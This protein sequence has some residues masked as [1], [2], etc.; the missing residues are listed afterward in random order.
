[1]PDG[2][3]EEKTMSEKAK[4]RL[5]KATLEFNGAEYTIQHPGNRAWLRIYQTLLADT[6]DLNIEK[7]LDWCF[8]HV[9]FPKE[10]AK[11]SLDTIPVAE[12]TDWNPT[13]PGE[14]IRAPDLLSESGTMRAESRYQ[15]MAKAK[16]ML[17]LPILK[18]MVSYHE[19]E[20]LTTLEL[21]E[22]NAAIRLFEKRERG[23]WRSIIHA[24]K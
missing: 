3:N 22:M 19:A 17:W 13:V 14:T 2:L 12:M 15:R 5:M 6:K 9:V 7:F 8:E 16:W 11:L 23:R 20:N 21:R 1:L 24:L 10:G 4:A 18:G